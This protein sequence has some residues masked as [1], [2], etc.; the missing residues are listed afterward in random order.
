[1]L[2]SSAVFL[3]FFLPAMLLG[4]YVV[5]RGMPNGKNLFLLAG[6]LF[7]Y[8]WGEPWFVLV[9]LGS[10]AVNYTLGRWAHR[11]RRTNCYMEPLLIV[12]LSVNLGLLFLFKYLTFTLESFTLF[13]FYPQIPGI[14]LP[15]G[16]S[17]FTFQ[18]LSY[19]IDV[20]KGKAQ[21]QRDPLKLGLYI[22]FFPQ[23]VAGPIV[24]YSHI[25][26]QLDDRHTTWDDFSSGCTRFLVGLSKKV[27][28]SNQL[29]VVADRAFDMEFGQLSAPFAWL[30]I[31][32]YTLQI[33]YDFSGYSDMAIG[34]GAMFGFR[35]QENFRHPYSSH[36]IAEFWRRW[37][38]SLS[39]WFRDYLYIPLGGS[40][41][42]KTVRNLFLVW[43]ATGLWHGANWT[44]IAWGLFYF[45]LLFLERFRGLGKGWPKWLQWAFTFLMVNLGWVL[46]RGDTLEHAWLYFLSMLG[47]GGG[48]SGFALLHLREYAVP[49]TAAILL[50]FP[51]S[52]RLITRGRQLLSRPIPAVIFGGI[53]AL[54]LLLLLLIC[55]CYL[56][57]GT[58][59]PFVYFSF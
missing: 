43:L 25:A 56:V 20:S 21:V 59:N 4:Y 23:L 52:P 57:K 30:G 44:F 53:N 39:S 12:T 14:R 22:S 19:V 33:Y 45:A 34:L 37:H 3:L 32:C 55:L 51:P 5:F 24:K 11:L 36:S 6:S 35:F 40:R 42:G 50:M 58:Y 48:E 15:I 46:F 7:F 49:L 10:I 54:A 31:L 28:L 26:P 13:G 17:F 18:A 2:F 47:A 8:A 29:A 27:L 38:I 16:I 41:T 1:M 9:M